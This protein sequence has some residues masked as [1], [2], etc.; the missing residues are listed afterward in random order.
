M[1]LLCTECNKKK[2]INEFN[3]LKLKYA[4]YDVV[5]ETTNEDLRS[6][7]KYAPATKHEYS[8]HYLV[9][10]DDDIIY[11]INWFQTLV[12]AAGNSDR[13]DTI[14]GLRGVVISGG[15]GSFEKYSNWPKAEASDYRSPRLVLTTGGGCIFPPETLA[16]IYEHKNTFMEEA[17]TSDDL[18]IKYFLNSKKCNEELVPHFPE[19]VTWPRSQNNSLWKQNLMLGGNDRAVNNLLSFCNLGLEE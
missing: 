18:F 10:A 15:K 8:K 6:Y 13:Q 17:P 16:D 14:F 11:P 2:D 1:K 9:T 12:N 3:N 7:K 19:I 5:F 4:K